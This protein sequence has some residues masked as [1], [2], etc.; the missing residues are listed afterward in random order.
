MIPTCGGNAVNPAGQQRTGEAENWSTCTLG[1]C[2]QSAQ[3]SA[4][5]FTESSGP[6]LGWDCRL[7]L[8]ASAM[9]PKFKK[10]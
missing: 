2:H 4:F 6:E 7:D 9:H 3:I 1:P 8:K 5:A 10:A